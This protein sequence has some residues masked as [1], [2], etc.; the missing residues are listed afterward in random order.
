MITLSAGLDT[1]KI[2]PTTSY[3]DTGSVTIDGDTIKNATLKAFGIQNMT[4]VLAQSLNTGSTWVEQKLGNSTF[5]N[6]IKKFGFGASTNIDLPGEVDGTVHTPAE[7][8]DFTY[9]TMS[10]GQGISVTPLQML[11]SF[12]AVANGGKLMTPYI[13]SKVVSS[14]GKTTT[15]KPKEIREV[16][17]SKADQEMVTMMVNEVQNGNGFQAKIAGYQVAGKTGTAQV[18]SLGGGYES[19]DNI[20]TFIGFA[21]ANDSE[22]CGF[23]QDRRTEGDSLG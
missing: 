8:N 17:S 14:D 13:V 12:A 5:Y 6:Y 19:G 23:S 21:P 4:Y 18:P 11:N 22:I 10:F 2:T 20:G 7:V 1:G 3:D 9:A 16:L 15:T